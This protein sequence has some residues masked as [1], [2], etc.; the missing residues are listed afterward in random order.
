MACHHSSG[1]TSWG[2]Q[3]EAV[4][5]PVD[6]GVG[7]ARLALGGEPARS[8]QDLEVGLGQGVRDAIKEI[9]AGS[10]HPNADWVEGWAFGNGKP[11]TIF[12]P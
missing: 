3:D 10:Y 12:P 7:G 11:P 6:H 1:R 9:G 5:G 4:H 8:D 2:H